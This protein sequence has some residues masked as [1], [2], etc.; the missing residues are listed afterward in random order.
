MGSNAFL[1]K[2]ADIPPGMLVAYKN[3]MAHPI[4][5]KSVTA[6]KGQSKPSKKKFRV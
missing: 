4:T 1:D 5:P 3:R 2:I 6:K